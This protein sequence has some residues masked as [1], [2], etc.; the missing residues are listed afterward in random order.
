MDGGGRRHRG[1]LT[2]ETGKS[3]YRDSGDALDQR[4]DQH[5]ARPT[6]GRYQASG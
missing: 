1:A 4:L 5:L 2:A 3:N 6:D